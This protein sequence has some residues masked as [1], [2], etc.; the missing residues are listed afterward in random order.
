MGAVVCSMG[1]G[2]SEEQDAEKI[3]VEDQSDNQL[4]VEDN[5]SMFSK[6]A[7]EAAE[8]AKTVKSDMG[9][10]WK[11]VSILDTKTKVTLGPLALRKAGAIVENMQNA[12]Y[13]DEKIN[14]VCRGL[15]CLDEESLQGAWKMFDLDGGG[16]LDAAEFKTALPLMGENVPQAKIDELYSMADTDG[17]GE[18]DYEEFCFL[19]KKMNPKE[20]ALSG[21][22]PEEEGAGFLSDMG[23][24]WKAVSILDTKTKVTLGPLA[25]RK[26]G[27]IV[28]N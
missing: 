10:G 18:I 3:E 11:A 20:Q 1:C 22:E 24:G 16:T 9:Q 25:L 12:G 23:Q 19:V 6:W 15:F 17:S 8:K 13:S 27:A 7:D 5:Q 28:E 14:I 4:S 2:G 26:A 21:E